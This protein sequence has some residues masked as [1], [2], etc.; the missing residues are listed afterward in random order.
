[1]ITLKTLLKAYYKKAVKN[2]LIDYS[3]NDFVSV[4]KLGKMK[5]M[6]K[7]GFPAIINKEILSEIFE[8][9]NEQVLII[10][11]N[12]DY[13]ICIEKMNR[14]TNY[15][16]ESNEKISIVM[17]L[18]SL[19]L[20]KSELFEIEKKAFEKKYRCQLENESQM[21]YFVDEEFKSIE[22]YKKEFVDS[23]SKIKSE[24]ESIFG[25]IINVELGCGFHID[26]N[27]NIIYILEM[28]NQLKTK[29]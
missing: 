11:D 24:K 3:Y 25:L 8:R 17:R 18:M 29:Q 14:L 15:I 16:K 20:A 6:F 28:L 5:S 9:V 19:E 10:T 1:M 22:F 12:Q 27:E 7:K 26:K 2:A 4:S 23:Q 21:Q 13:N